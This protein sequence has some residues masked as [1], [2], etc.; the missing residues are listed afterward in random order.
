M[1]VDND[2]NSR[3]AGPDGPV[4]MEDVHLTEK[5]AHLDRARIPERVVHARG[6]G[7]HGV[8]EVT[9]DVPGGA[10][11]RD[12]GVAAGQRRVR[13][14]RMWVLTPMAT[15]SSRMRMG[16]ESIAKMAVA[17]MVSQSKERVVT[18]AL[19]CRPSPLR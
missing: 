7:A 11:Q 19:T 13:I 5:L 10:Y 17:P 8:F 4:L 16:V 9:G 6:A 3:T 1:P 15:T 18:F 14:N 12:L 2:L